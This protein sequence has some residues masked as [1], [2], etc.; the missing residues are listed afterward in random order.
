MESGSKV[1]TWGE[2]ERDSTTNNIRE[3]GLS[4]VENLG[5]AR[6]LLAQ[7]KT[8]TGEAGKL[9]PIDAQL[10]VAEEER[11]ILQ[12]KVKR[13][14]VDKGQATPAEFK[15][16]LEASNL[17]ISGLNDQ[18]AEAGKPLTLL[19]NR[20]TQEINSIKTQLEQLQ[21]PDKIAALGGEAAADKQRTE[22]QR[23][24]DPKKDFWRQV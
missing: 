9:R 3:Q 11:A 21:D 2:Y 15:Q 6:L 20:T 1:K 13:D 18:R 7:F 16:K 14:F 17:K 22:L 4:N 10:K 5:D 19:L 24:L 12:A 8:G 23:Q